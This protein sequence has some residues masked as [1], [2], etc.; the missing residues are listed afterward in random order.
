MKGTD[1]L[2]F[3]PRALPL[4]LCTF[5]FFCLLFLS[6]PAIDADEFTRTSRY[7]ARLFSYGLLIVDTRMGDVR[8]EGWDEPRVEVEAEKTVR[9][10]SERK[11]QPL[12][13]LIRIELAGQDK[14]VRLRTIYPKR[15]W[16]RPFRDGSKLSANL[17]VKMP[18]DANLT[19]RCVDGDVRVTGLVSR[20]QLRVNYGDVEIDVPDVYRLR[21]LDAHTWLG[22]VQSDLHGLP[23]D[24]AGFRRRLFFEN[25]QGRQD[26]LVRVRM[27]GVFVFGGPE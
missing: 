27:G 9:A 23:Q 21:S 17:R 5:S 25:S 4:T 11:A 20:E 24:S 12:F 22:Y 16:R 19:L 3:R 8:I 7:A 2:K 1:R 6:P 26:I 18:Y 15:S 14:E 10:G 13:D